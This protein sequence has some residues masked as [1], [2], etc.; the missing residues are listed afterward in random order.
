MPPKGCEDFSLQPSNPSSAKTFYPST[1]K[2]LAA[3][4]FVRNLEARLNEDRKPGPTS[5]AVSGPQCF[6][7]KTDF[8]PYFGK[9]TGPNM[10]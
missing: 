2:Q 3:D 5:T 10:K 8:G 9:C 6:P 1:S 7:I 4:A